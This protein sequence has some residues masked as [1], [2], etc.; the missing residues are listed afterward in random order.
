MSFRDAPSSP[1]LK[2]NSCAEKRLNQSDFR[3]R[4]GEANIA[5]GAQPELAS[6]IKINDETVQMSDASQPLDQTL[7]Q[8]VQK[9]AAGSKCQEEFQRR[10]S[11]HDGLKAY[12][13]SLKEGCPFIIASHP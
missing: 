8:L 4:K 13:V 9:L 7:I 1:D 11:G 2:I 12:E 6:T 10:W 3:H 5:L